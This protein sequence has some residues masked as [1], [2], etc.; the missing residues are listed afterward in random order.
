MEW[1]GQD[2][3][4]LV[5]RSGKSIGRFDGQQVV[6]LADLPKTGGNAQVLMVADLLGDFR[7]ELV[8]SGTDEA[9]NPGIFIY[10]STT[11]IATRQVTRTAKHDYQMWMARNL[12]GGYGAYF[13]SAR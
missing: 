3:R 8:L 9:G 12:I 10:T 11:P 7:D 2:G 4:E 5:A 6:L 13:E 1:D